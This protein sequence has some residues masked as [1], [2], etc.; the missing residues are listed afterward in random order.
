MRP[1]ENMVDKSF[2]SGKVVSR[3]ISKDI[4]PK[5]KENCFWAGVFGIV[6]I[7]NHS[8]IDY[9][10]PLLSQVQIKSAEAEAKVFHICLLFSSIY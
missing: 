1:L 3:K 6:G 4:D 9:S 7:H 2:V 8:E 5:V 10:D